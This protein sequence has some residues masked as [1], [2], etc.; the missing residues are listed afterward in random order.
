MEIALK[1][2]ILADYS[3]KNNVNV[4][5]LT[6]VGVLPCYSRV[7]QLRSTPQLLH[8]EIPDRTLSVSCLP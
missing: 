8:P 6:Q 5:A 3:K 2:L 7:Q 4:A 1:D